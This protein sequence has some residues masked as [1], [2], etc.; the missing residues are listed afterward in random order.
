MKH[1]I[2]V[3]DLQYGSTGKGQIAGTVGRRWA[4]DTVVCANGPNAGHTYTWTI[5]HGVLNHGGPTRKIVHTA[6][7]VG[8]VLP[9]VRNILIGPGA[10]VDIERLKREVL[11][12][13]DLLIGKRLVIHPNAAIVTQEHRDWEKGLIGIGSTMKGTA[14]AVIAKMRRLPGA[15]I[16]RHYRIPLELIYS[17][18]GPEC[19]NVVVDEIE[20]NDAINSSHKLLVEGA[21]G[22][23]LSIHSHF[24]PHCTSRDVGINQLW[25]DCR[26]PVITTSTYFDSSIQVIGVARTYPI[27]VANRYNKDTGEQVGYSGDC[28]PD[29]QEIQWH[30]IGRVAELTTVTQLPRRLFTFSLKQILDAVRYNAPTSI[31]LTFCDY[32]SDVYPQHP[33]ASGGNWEVGRDGPIS[34]GVMSYIRRI[35]AAAECNV[36]YLSYGPTDADVYSRDVVVGNTLNTLRMPLETLE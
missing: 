2:V 6:M 32:V 24:Y 20:Y 15:D 3:V 23:S 26:L 16:A 4:P 31:A 35:E 22:A 29:Q 30:S 11:E 18:R 36:E 5:D 10:V 17:G 12:S 8:A 7:P 13:A 14:E 25:A 1:V 21:Q 27:R 19:F 28:W 34:P 9:S 33:Q